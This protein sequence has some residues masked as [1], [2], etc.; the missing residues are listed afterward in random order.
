VDRS[1][2]K[3]L[4]SEPTVGRSRLLLADDH[5]LVTQGI[6][7]L[8]EP[9]FDLVGFA[10]NGRQLL[11]LAQDLV[12]DAILMDISMPLLNGI[13]TTRQLRSAGIEIPI[14]IVTMHADVTYLQEAMW[15]GASGYVLKK[16]AAS[17]LVQAVTTVLQ[18]N[19]YITP[20]LPG[21]GERSKEQ[22]DLTARQREVLQLVSEGF[23]AKEIA[24]MLNISVKTAEFHKANIMQKLGVRTVAQLTR[25]AMK[26]GLSGE[27]EA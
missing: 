8:L 5:V 27:L 4:I 21:I 17:E 26:H 22:H 19:R 7:K 18:G 13:E 9:Y 11:Q 16:S 2:A 15:A 12:P 6:A 3:N 1:T 23:S 14:I 25:Y 24:S 20:S 10:E